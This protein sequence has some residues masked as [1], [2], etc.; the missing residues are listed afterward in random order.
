VEVLL[1][2]MA[3]VKRERSAEIVM[4][5]L[6]L[7]FLGLSFRIHLELYSHLQKGVM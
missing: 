2:S 1:R 6:F 4:Y 5:A 7:Y 3:I